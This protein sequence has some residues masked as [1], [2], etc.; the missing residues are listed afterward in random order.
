MLCTCVRTVFELIPIFA[1][2]TFP[3]A[4]SHQERQDLSFASR[5][6]RRKERYLLVPSREVPG[7]QPMRQNAVSIHRGPNGI[8]ELLDGGVL[9]QVPHETD[10]ERLIDNRSLAESCQ[11]DDLR[12]RDDARGSPDQRPGHSDPGDRCP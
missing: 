6:L 5:E 3:S 9:G 10:P 12:R 11:R 7:R 8:H 2:A 4:P 1:A